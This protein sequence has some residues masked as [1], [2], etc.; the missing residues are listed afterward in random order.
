LPFL[1]AELHGH[2]HRLAPDF[3]EITN[4]RDGHATGLKQEV[5]LGHGQHLCR[6]TFE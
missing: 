5:T 1:P 3:S 2:G 4:Q 6:L